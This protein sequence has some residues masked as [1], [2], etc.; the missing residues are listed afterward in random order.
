MFGESSNDKG[1]KP[2]PAA[3]RVEAPAKAKSFGSSDSGDKLAE[4]NR[5]LAALEKA[6][7]SLKT[8]QT[9]SKAPAAAG[10]ATKNDFETSDHSEDDEIEEM[11]SGSV[12]SDE[13]LSVGGA[14]SDSNSFLADS[15]SVR[16]KGT[17]Q[18]SKAQK[19]KN[20]STSSQGSQSIEFST[21]EQEISGSH[22]A[23]DDFDF[24]TRAAPPRGGRKSGW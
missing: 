20:A 13:G 21:T 12:S 10:A 18:A 22:A 24:T 19:S 11:L 23:L 4:V 16:D 1:K 2:A 7:S 15:T 6:D 14:D 5:K 3:A 17:S 9:S 8:L